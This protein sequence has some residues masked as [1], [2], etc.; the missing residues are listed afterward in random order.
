MEK[1][2][3]IQRAEA[4][5]E[6]AL[7]E[8]GDGRRN[9]FSLRV[10]TLKGESKWFAHCYQTGKSDPQRELDQRRRNIQPCDAQGNPTGHMVSISIDLITE[11][12]GRRVH[13]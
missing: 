11:Y 13:L 3:S 7:R 8:T 4:L 10:V 5:R 1:Q 9:I 6:M 2:K 12:N